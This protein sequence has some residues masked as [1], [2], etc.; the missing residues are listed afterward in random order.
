MMQ[1]IQLWLPTR[2]SSLADPAVLADME[3]AFQ[4]WEG[5]RT[6]WLLPDTT[7]LPD[8]LVMR[9]SEGP[10]RYDMLRAVRA[11]SLPTEQRRVGLR[12]GATDPRAT[13]RNFLREALTGKFQDAARHRQAQD[14]CRRAD[15][16]AQRDG[17][18]SSADSRHY[19]RPICELVVELETS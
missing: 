18:E 16:R 3:R 5:A 7:L 8:L 17:Q 14:G 19:A 2:I 1:P 11:R 9:W 6:V 12:P 4:V 10:T 15:H 13:L